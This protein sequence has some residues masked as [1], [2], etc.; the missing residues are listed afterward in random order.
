ME[1]LATNTSAENMLR[2]GT[3]TTV[4]PA[5]PEPL[6]STAR[7]ASRSKLIDFCLKY[8]TGAQVPPALPVAP[9]IGS[10]RSLTIT[11]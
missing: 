1:Q 2:A 10:P 4:K 6:P 5:V 3:S 8:R 11:S 9:L 7:H